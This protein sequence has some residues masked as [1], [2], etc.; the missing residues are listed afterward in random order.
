MM[1]M[2]RKRRNDEVKKNPYKNPV[3]HGRKKTTNYDDDD[4]YSSSAFFQKKKKN[5][6]GKYLAMA[7]YI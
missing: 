3:I 2:T 1:T 5:R 7:K 4:F 6:S